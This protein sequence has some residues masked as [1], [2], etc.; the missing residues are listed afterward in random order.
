M[1]PSPPDASTSSDDDFARWLD[2]RPEDDGPL[3][4]DEQAALA[5]SDVDIAEGRT[6]SFEAIKAIDRAIAGLPPDHV[7]PD[8]AAAALATGH[9][10]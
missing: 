4:P 1:S 9:Q 10:R 6:T 2:S 5:E 3:T 7:F 8:A